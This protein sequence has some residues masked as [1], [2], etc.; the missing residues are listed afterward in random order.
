MPF[1]SGKYVGAGERAQLLNDLY[2]HHAAVNVLRAALTHPLVGRVAL[3]S[4]F[5]AESVVLLHMISKI[6]PDAPVLL[7][8]TQMLFPE[9]LQYQADVASE[10]GLTNVQRISSGILETEDPQNALHQSDPDLCCHIRKVAPLQNALQ[11]YDAW[12]TGRKRFQTANRA[13]LPHFEAETET[14]LKINPLAFWTKDDVRDYVIN[15]RLPQ[16]PLVAKG[17]RSIGCLPCTA[18]GEDRMGRWAGQDKTEC[19]IH[20]VDGHTIRQGASE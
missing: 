12:I 17:Y 8:D 10:L 1:D 2:R 15:N 19:G 20:F 9:T 18:K 6:A 5:G 13:D 4:S 3:V 11:P 14:R 16:H 7:I